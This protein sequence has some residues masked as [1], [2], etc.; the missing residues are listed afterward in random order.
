MRRGLTREGAKL[1][2]GEGGRGR[3]QREELREKKG[4]GRGL[5][6]QPFFGLPPYTVF[7]VN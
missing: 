5:T 6:L 2:A 1:I 4:R 3:G 7:S